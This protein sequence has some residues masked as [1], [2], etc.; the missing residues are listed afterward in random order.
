MEKSAKLSEAGKKGAETVWGRRAQNEANKRSNRAMATPYAEAMDF[1]HVKDS[2][3]EVGKDG[4]P[5]TIYQSHI[6]EEVPPPQET[7]GAGAR[8]EEVVA[9]PPY[10]NHISDVEYQAFCVHCAEL[11]FDVPG[12]PLALRIA[13]KYRGIPLNTLPKFA[14]QK[15]P[16]L[17]NDDSITRQQIEMEIARQKHAAEHPGAFPRKPTEHE[18]KTAQAL[19]ILKRATKAAGR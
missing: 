13:R 10:E 9:S 17:W 19:E 11:G 5:P 16:G 8:E 7:L 4:L 12:R 14:T 18:Q 1:D 15:G 6:T 2:Q 3:S